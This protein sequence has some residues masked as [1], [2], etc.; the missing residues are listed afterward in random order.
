MPTKT[1]SDRCPPLQDC[2]DRWGL[3]VDYTRSLASTTNKTDHSHMARACSRF[4]LDQSPS[5]R[6]ARWLNS[7]AGK[8]AHTFFCHHTHAAEQTMLHMQ[9]PVVFHLC[10][11]GQYPLAGVSRTDCFFVFSIFPKCRTQERQAHSSCAAEASQ[12]EREG[13]S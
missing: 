6:R 10:K 3:G 8:S 13:A 11:R 5:Y 7:S 4:H 12:K 1:R 9:S 2:W